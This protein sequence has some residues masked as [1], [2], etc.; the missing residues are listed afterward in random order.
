MRRPWHDP[1]SRD[2]WGVLPRVFRFASVQ[3]D[4]WKEHTVARNIACRGKTGFF[5]SRDSRRKHR[6]TLWR[7]NSKKTPKLRLKNLS[8]WNRKI[9]KTQDK[10]KNKKL[11]ESYFLTKMQS[12][13]RKTRKPSIPCLFV[14]SPTPLDG[15]GY[16]CK[17]NQTAKVPLLMDGDVWRR[18]EWGRVV[19]PKKNKKNTWKYGKE[20]YKNR[21]EA[22]RLF[23]RLKAIARVFS[24]LDKLDVTFTGFTNVRPHLFN[25]LR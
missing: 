3:I 21:N 20:L 13:M 8:K 15:N 22:E 25:T 11:R 18:W 1:I 23:R 2:N 7:K 12:G 16:H 17:V 9:P 24:C 19:P 14:V 6:E 5:W 4:S 10:D